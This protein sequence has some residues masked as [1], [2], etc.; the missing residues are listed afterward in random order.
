MVTGITSLRKAAV[1]LLTTATLGSAPAFAQGPTQAQKENPSFFAMA[2]DLAIV[3]PLMLA[4]TVV[5]G[6]VFVVS[7]PFAAMGGNIAQSGRTLVAQPFKATFVRCLGCS[8]PSEEG[9]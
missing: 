1:V 7:A 5:G 3:R 2:G 8:F 6:A 4:T 9:L